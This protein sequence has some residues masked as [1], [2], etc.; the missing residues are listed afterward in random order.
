[1]MS[2]TGSID[3][4]R[5]A[6]LLEVAQQGLGDLVLFGTTLALSLSARSRGASPVCVA[7]TKSSPKT[8]A[9][10]RAYRCWRT[11]GAA[12]SA[13]RGRSRSPA[14]GRAA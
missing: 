4:M 6:V 11:S 5:P 10:P 12:H 7:C 14:R 13:A 2:A 9:S 8:M 1:M 3:S